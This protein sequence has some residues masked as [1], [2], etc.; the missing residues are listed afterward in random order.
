MYTLSIIIPVYNSEKYLPHL[1]TQ[2]E[3]LDRKKIEI[4]FVDDGSNDGSKNIIKKAIRKNIKYIYQKNSGAPSARNKGLMESEGKYVYFIDSDDLLNLYGLKK[5]IQY[6]ENKIHLDV[7][8]ANFE[9]VDSSNSSFIYENFVYSDLPKK[10]EACHLSPIPGNKIYRKKYLLDNNI[11]FFNV[12]IGQDLNFFLKAIDSA[13]IIEYCNESIYRYFI[14]ENSISTSYDSR[15]AD[16][17]LSIDNAENCCN[18]ID[19]TTFNAIKYTHFNYQLTK[20]PK[21]KQ[22]D[23]QRYVVKKLTDSIKK[24]P[25]KDAIN[26]CNC[27]ILFCNFIRRKILEFKY[28]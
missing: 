1:L 9:Y 12:R 25:R 6:L 8:I 10:N 7:L 5:I 21:I 11:Y 13:S 24:I 28:L 18:T 22:K 19:K 2:L 17:I 16:I 3:Q 20:V 26:N 27:K 23:Q 14:R 4:I 15:I